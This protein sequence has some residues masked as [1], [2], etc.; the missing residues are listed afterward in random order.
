VENAEEHKEAVIMPI[1]VEKDTSR[2]AV[3]V[4]EPSLS[5]FAMAVQEWKATSGDPTLNDILP[6]AEA[7]LLER[8]ETRA[9]GLLRFAQEA[10]AWHETTGDPTIGHLL[11]MARDAVAIAEGRAPGT[12]E[13][14]SS[15]DVQADA[16]KV[17]SRYA[18]GEK[19]ANLY[20]DDQDFADALRD[21]AGPDF[22]YPDFSWLT[23]REAA[24]LAERMGR[25]FVAE[26]APDPHQAML[27]EQGAALELREGQVAENLR[28]YLNTPELVDGWITEKAVALKDG[29][30]KYTQYLKTPGGGLILRSALE[31]DHPESP[32][33]LVR[34]FEA[35]ERLM[36]QTTKLPG[37]EAPSGVT[38]PQTPKLTSRELSEQYPAR[39]SM[40]P[41]VVEQLYLLREAEVASL[42][43]R[44]VI[45]VGDLANLDR[46][47]RF[48]VADS[49]FK[50]CSPDARNTLLVDQ[51]HGVRSA[52]VL[53]KL[54]LEN[55]ASKQSTPTLDM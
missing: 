35:G 2:Q 11:P 29:S 50:Y 32:Q 15:I 22:E 13:P 45:E 17:L 12:E 3:L 49:L 26:S 24:T 8:G 21:L 25:S 39:G 37:P 16:K 55:E 7:A 6:I 43:S 47:A 54:D 14:R 42:A 5:A 48:M 44:D 28:Q 38:V 27:R 19:V 30:V 52:A 53:A 31:P 41:R 40:P 34:R 46:G 9:T 4:A 20:D 10:L 18:P 23:V 33:G 1:S 51:H 36:P